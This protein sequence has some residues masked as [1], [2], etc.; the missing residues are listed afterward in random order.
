M[1]VKQS[2]CVHSQHD[3]EGSLINNTDFVTSS[4]SVDNSLVFPTKLAGEKVHCHC[5]QICSDIDIDSL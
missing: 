1:S 2:C 5:C 4:L 3:H